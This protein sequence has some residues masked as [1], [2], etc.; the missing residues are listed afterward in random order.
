MKT[1]DQGKKVEL[2]CPREKIW[3]VGKKDADRRWNCDCPSSNS[4]LVVSVITSVK[5]RQEEFKEMLESLS[6]VI[7]PTDYILEHVVHDFDGELERKIAIQEISK[8]HT[9]YES[10]RDEG[11]YD[12]FNLGLTL[13]SGNLISFLNSDDLYSSDFLLTATRTMNITGADWV[14]GDVQ[15]FG[16][17][18]EI[19]RGK[20]LY[21]R[22]SWRR[23]SMFHHPTVIARSDL[24]KKIGY[25]KTEV[26]GTKVKYAADYLWFLE[27]QKSGA[28][29]AYNPRIRNYMRTGGVSSQNLFEILNEGK[30]MARKVYPA[31]YLEI[32]IVWNLSKL[33]L[34]IKKDMRFNFIKKILFRFYRP[35]GLLRRSIF[36]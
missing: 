19:Y 29:G 9:V 4:N 17:S 20:P 34:F 5:D 30:K 12:G 23:F 33:D 21:F 32:S 2:F 10:S 18:D 28:L 24:F 14:F 25:F 31:R 11:L 13:A 16:D 6:N 26:R 36:E 3:K 15:M 1:V 8:H 27:A 7:V 22:N 35:L